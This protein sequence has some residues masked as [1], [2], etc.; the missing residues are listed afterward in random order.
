MCRG[1][2]RKAKADLKL[3]LARDVKNN[4]KMFFKYINN[5]EKQKENTGLL[6]NRRVNH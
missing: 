2:V 6:L 4:T 3:N 5:K 1:V